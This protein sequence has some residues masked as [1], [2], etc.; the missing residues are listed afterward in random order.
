MKLAKLM[1]ADDVLLFRKGDVN[2]MMLILKSLK[3]FSNAS[4]LSFSPS[5]SPAYFRGITADTKEDILRVSRFTEGKLPFKY[6]A[7]PIQTTRLQRVDCESLIEQ[8]CDRIHNYGA[9]K[10]SYAGRLVLVNVV[11]TSLHFYWASLFPK[12]EGGLGIKNLELS[13]VAMIGRLVDWVAQKRDSIWV[14]WVYANYIKDQDWMDY[15]ASSGTS[16]VWR[17]VRAVKQKLADGYNDGVWTAQ[18]HGYTPSGCYEWLRGSGQTQAWTGAVWNDWVIPKHQVFGWLNA[19]GGLGTKDRLKKI[20]V[21]ED[22]N[23]SICGQGSEAREH[24][25]LNCEYSRRVITEVQ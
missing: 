24:L 2:S 21:L 4:G 6:L 23:C 10:F 8:I 12:A 14:R 9:R 17:R 11:L 7:M 22:D 20:G 15:Q 16:W 13:N 25:F 19:Q 18:P 5:K 3:T 1:F